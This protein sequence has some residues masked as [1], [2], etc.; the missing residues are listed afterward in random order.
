[1]RNIILLLIIMS[2]VSC[3]PDKC[4][5]TVC[6]NEGVCVQGKCSCLNGYEGPNCAE[7]WNERFVGSWLQTDKFIG[8]TSDLVL[9]NHI[10]VLAAERP[11]EFLV[12]NFMGGFDSIYCKRKSYNELVFLTRY[13]SDSVFVLSTG[14]ATYNPADSIVTGQFTFR[15]GSNTYIYNTVWTR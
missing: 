7:R 5:D 1:M 15:G 2:L 12:L 13:S 6:L 10:T 14:T 11:D 4:S 9:Q 3:Q 8:D